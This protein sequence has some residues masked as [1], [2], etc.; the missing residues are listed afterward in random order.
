MPVRFRN[1]KDELK[2][3]K[4]RG[5]GRHQAQDKNEAFVLA[6][7]A[8]ILIRHMDRY[9]V[10]CDKVLRLVCWVL[11]QE[12]HRLGQF[13]VNQFVDEDQED[14]EAELSGH[15]TD[16]DEYAGELWR[17]VSGMNA[18][19][20]QE[21][22]REAIRLT[23]LRRASLQYGG[24]S[25]LEKNL[26]VIRSM[27]G[28]TDEELRFCTFLF[29]VSNYEPV[30]AY[31]VDYL[32][33]QMYSGRSY[34]ANALNISK[35]KIGS[36]M[37][38]KLSKIGFFETDKYQFSVEDAF[39]PLFEDPSSQLIAR[40]YF[41]RLNTRTIPLSHHFVGEKAIAHT[42]G[43][44]REKSETST[45]I[46][47]YGSP[48][49]GKTSFAGGIAK[50]AGIPSY[51]IVR[52][53]TN[54]THNRRAA[55]LACIN[56]TNTDPGSLIVVDE[57]DNLLNTELSWLVRGETQDKGWLNDLMDTPGLRMMWITNQ[58]DDID[59]SVLR[60][61]SFSIHFKPFNKR[62]RIQL[63][64]NILKKNRMKRFFTLP[65]M[66]KLAEKYCV[67]AGVLDLA[68]KKAKQMGLN[69]KHAVMEAVTLSL[70]AHETL[71]NSGRERVD[72]DQIDRH[73]S[74]EGLHITANIHDLMAQMKKFDAWLR[75]S[76]SQE[77]WGM[78]LLFYGPPGS[79][80]SELA[81]YMGKYL[82]RPIITRRASDIQSKYVGESETNIREAFEEAEREEAILVMDEA[83]SLLFNRDRARY[84]WEISLTNEFLTSMERFR[85]ILICT[86]NRIGDLDAASI[87]R[88][89]ETVGFRFLTPQGNLIFYDKMFSN[90][91]MGPMSTAEKM[92]LKGLRD[93]TPGDFKTVRDR[94][95]FYD[96]SDLTHKSL[97]RA[98]AEEARMKRRQKGEKEI[99]F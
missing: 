4:R 88:F 10:L 90:R 23:D 97:I 76:G 49:T 56:M 41:V 45:H 95:R 18:R 9:R 87:R 77:A 28:L 36:I 40:E 82:D 84:S 22:I 58:V 12:R 13:I 35:R 32:Q 17:I 74:L 25:E 37:S 8:A 39:R 6:C 66:E 44:L 11:G 46:L 30:D 65:D 15:M 85:G 31:F 38:G 24:K 21:V 2:K 64:V 3:R 50:E 99:G 68:V 5:K 53:E 26:D 61:F 1:L 34:L 27:F 67:S 63:W 54:T 48:G 71:Q 96:A 94:F 78:N 43:L 20:H 33:C 80:K 72:R 98:L 29:I 91:G 70:E 47:L 51:R 14:L 52:G 42:L 7:T 55:T 86:S 59:P 19:L 92:R 62:Q 89:H 79:G 83:E 75:T 60:R 69:S 73:Y 81:R 93:L 57:A 16:Y